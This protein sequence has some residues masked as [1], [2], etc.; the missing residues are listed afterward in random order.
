MKSFIRLS[1]LIFIPLIISCSDHCSK[2]ESESYS[3]EVL[4]IEEEAKSSLRTLDTYIGEDKYRTQPYEAYRLMYGS[5]ESVEKMLIRIG[6][7][8]DGYYI[9]NKAFTAKSTPNNQG[10][11]VELLEN[12]V[13]VLDKK[14]WLDFQSTI[15]NMS[16]WTMPEMTNHTGYRGVS[17]FIDG[18]RPQAKECGKRTEH[19]V[20]RWNPTA[21]NYYAIANKMIRLLKSYKAK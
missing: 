5:A 20:T 4:L 14:D 17:Y 9:I 6:E 13:Y 12:N 11:K 19:L 15:Y 2:F 1:T 16:Y 3:E 7:N 21:D 8:D 10:M 18:Y